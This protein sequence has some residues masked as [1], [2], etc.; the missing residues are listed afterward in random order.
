MDHSLSAVLAVAALAAAL[1]YWLRYCTRDDPG[2]RGA[3]VKAAST[4]LLAAILWLAVAR[5]Q[6]LWPIALGLTLGALGDWFLARRGQAAF[7]AGM[8]AFAAGHLA[9]AGGM[10]AWAAKPGLDGWTGAEIVAAGILAGLLAST[11]FWLLPR[12]GALRAPVA[13]YVAMIGLM[14]LAAIVLPAQSGQGGLRLGAALFILSD[15]LLALRLFVVQIPA[16]Q[17]L[18]SRLLWP[19]YWAGQALIGWSALAYWQVRG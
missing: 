13:G 5:G 6:G 3:A 17:A 16:Q 18:L 14:G 4:A 10:L 7:L 1:V 15:L 8:A 19:A 2:A 11:P 9:Y 12:T